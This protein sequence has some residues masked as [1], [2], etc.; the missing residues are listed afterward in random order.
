MQV[1]T[2]FIFVNE[3]CIIPSASHPSKVNCASILTRSK[4]SITFYTLGAELQKSSPSASQPCDP[5]HLTLPTVFRIRH[6]ST[7]KG[8]NLHISQSTL[9]FFL[10]TE[11]ENAP[12]T[13]S[14]LNAIFRTPFRVILHKI[15]LI[16]PNQNSF[17]FFAD[18][19]TPCTLYTPDSRNHHCSYPF[20]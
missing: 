1:T 9:P 5:T 4:N 10:E 17:S 11:Q 19:V 16:W 14:Q 8:G 2:Y 13:P 12:I 6:L 7:F 20:T 18:S 15:Y 3:K